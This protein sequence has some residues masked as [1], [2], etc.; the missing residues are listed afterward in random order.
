[1]RFL[2]FCNWSVIQQHLL[3]AVQNN[4]HFKIHWSVTE[5]HLTAIQ[6]NGCCKTHQFCTQLS[7]EKLLLSLWQGWFSQV[8]AGLRQGQGQAVLHN[9]QQQAPAIKLP[10]IQ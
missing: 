2:F 6:Y 7:L 3:A 4:S 8:A 1:M 10:G 5:Q 9:K